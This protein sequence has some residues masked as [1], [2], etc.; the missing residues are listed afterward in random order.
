MLKSSFPFQRRI[1]DLDLET[2]GHNSHPSSRPIQ[3]PLH[4]YS[5][6]MYTPLVYKVHI[7]FMPS[8]TPWCTFDTLDYYPSHLHL[9]LIHITQIY[10]CM[11]KVAH[12]QFTCPSRVS[13]HSRKSSRQR[14]WLSLDIEIR[15][16][17]SFVT[18]MVFKTP[19]CYHSNLILNL[20]SYV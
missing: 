9:Y 11:C 10:K 16:R 8:R 4:L 13:Y 17:H 14:T 15:E 12:P 3:C 1:F 6:S 5:F 20:I 2:V 18:P 7:T 19:L